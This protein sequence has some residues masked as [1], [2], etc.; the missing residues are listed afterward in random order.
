MRR[1]ALW[2][3]CALAACGRDTTEPSPQG[4]RSFCPQTFEWH[5]VDPAMDYEQHALDIVSNT[6]RMTLFQDSLLEGRGD[7]FVNFKTRLGQDSAVQRYRVLWPYVGKY[8][9]Q[10]DTVKIGYADVWLARNDVISLFLPDG[11]RTISLDPLVV[12]DMR[13]G[14]C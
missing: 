11:L 1:I 7:L 12:L 4:D 8:T 9:V 5:V 3:C 6:H 14:R 10:G 13:W 2:L